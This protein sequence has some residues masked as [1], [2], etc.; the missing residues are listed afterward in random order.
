MGELNLDD[1]DINDPW[2]DVRNS[3]VTKSFVTDGPAQEETAVPE[4]QVRAAFYDFWS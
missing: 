3:S 4:F 2:R 1:S